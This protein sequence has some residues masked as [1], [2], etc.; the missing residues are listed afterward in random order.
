MS[1]SSSA[2]NSP[3]TLF[4]LTAPLAFRL[5]EASS[6]EDTGAELSV[7]FFLSRL[8]SLPRAGLALPVIRWLAVP[9]VVGREVSGVGTGVESALVS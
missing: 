9:G 4:F 1:S 8:D 7:A 5:A 6:P 3:Q 2:P